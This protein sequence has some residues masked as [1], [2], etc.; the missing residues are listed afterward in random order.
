MH[1]TDRLAAL[2]KE[3]NELG[4]EVAETEDGLRIRPRPL[5]GGI[6]HTYEDHRLATAAAVLGLAVRGRPDRERGDHGQDPA[7]LPRACGPECFRR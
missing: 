6:F 2:T 7:R 4:G 1:E 3:I 5:H